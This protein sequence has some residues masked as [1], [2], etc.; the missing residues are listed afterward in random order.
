MVKIKG[1]AF[2]DDYLT[3]LLHRIK[4]SPHLAD[5][6]DEGHKG[7]NVTFSDPENMFNSFPEFKTYFEAIRDPDCNLFHIVALV[8]GSGGIIER[9]KDKELN[10]YN[11]PKI[12]NVLYVHV[13]DDVTGG[14]VIFEDGSTLSPE[15]NLLVTFPSTFEHSVTQ[16]TTNDKRVCLV[17]EQYKE[18]TFFTNKYNISKI[19][20]G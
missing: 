5:T 13:P 11:Y 19:V 9:H 14:Q 7:F 3:T 2:S 12:T 18:L 16:V 4:E 8:I 1:N 15:T 20:K 17:C 10:V 6:G